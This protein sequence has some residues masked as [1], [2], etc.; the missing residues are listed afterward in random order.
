MGDTYNKTITYVLDEMCKCVGT[1]FKDTNFK[2][3]NWFM[4]HTWNVLEETAFKNWLVT[5]LQYN[6]TARKEFLSINHGYYVKKAKIEKEV[7]LFI[8]NYGWKTRQ[9]TEK[10]I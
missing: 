3:S 6:A 10:N 5:Y 4:N 1:T 9:L 8:W 2:D 7:H